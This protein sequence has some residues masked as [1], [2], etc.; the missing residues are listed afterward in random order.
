MDARSYR[1]GRRELWRARLY[2]WRERLRRPAV[3]GLLLSGLAILVGAG[4]WY[5]EETSFARRAV[6]TSAVI[7]Q[8]DPPIRIENQ[9]GPPALVVHG[10]L[11][12]RVD[13]RTIHARVRLATCSTSACA[14]AIRNR[15]GRLITIAYDPERVTHVHP[16]R[17]STP[18]TPLFMLLVG[19]GVILM[20]GGLH[21]LFLDFGIPLTKSGQRRYA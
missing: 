2:G 6:S 3:W 20:G 13:G 9:D 16:G 1:I 11:R 18:V 21:T 4:W 5:A 12:F 10:V 15:Q 8:V 19:F 14:A 7:Q 17:G